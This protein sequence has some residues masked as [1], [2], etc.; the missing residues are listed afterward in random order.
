MEIILWMVFGAIVCHV[1]AK[2]IGNIILAIVLAAIFIAIAKSG[3]L[4]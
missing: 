2:F 4:I 3:G 1:V